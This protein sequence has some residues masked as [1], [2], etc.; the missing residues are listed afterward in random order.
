[1]NE[2]LDKLF[3]D[4]FQTT[5]QVGRSPSKPQDLDLLAEKARCSAILAQDEER[6]KT[7]ASYRKKVTD[8]IQ[9]GLHERAILFLAMDAIAVCSGDLA[10]ADRNKKAI[11]ERAPS[12]KKEK[13]K[14]D[15]DDLLF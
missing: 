14:A 6:K 11:I 12:A 2:D 13:S 5:H 15:V 8:A 4:L 1:M 10:E 7:L 9:Q 3:C